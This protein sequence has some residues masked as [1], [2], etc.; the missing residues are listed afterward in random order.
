M[1]GSVSRVWRVAMTELSAAVRSRRA[2]VVTLLFL[3][4]AV[5]VMYGT[6]SAFAAME[7]EVLA[8]LGLPASDHPGSVTTALW[9]SKPFLRV[10][11]RMVGDSL[12]FADIRGR[13]PILLA[14]AMFIFQIVPLLTLMVSAPR[15][16][17]DL[18]SGAARYW[19]VRV[20]RTEWSLGKF[21][22]EAALLA[23]AMLGGA[24]AAWAVVV[25][26][27]PGLSGAG[28]LPGLVDWSARAWLYAFGWL[29]LFMGLSHIV[30]SGGKATALGILALLGAAAWSPMLGNFT[31]ALPWLE[32]LDGLVPQSA[33][34]CLWRR[35]VPA[36]AFGAVHLA[37]LAFL[38]LSLGAAV[39]RRRDV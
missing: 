13:H 25:W 7:R 17:D 37:A 32:H 31:D 5:I 14:Y 12:V 20:T 24:L 39:F 2:L 15:V 1:T 11:D 16:A 28:L 3:A 35:S 10:I 38:Y 9:K 4:V 22:G 33:Q 26:R 34:A 19:L 29:G 8:G 21:L 27:L 30:R 36:L 18:R 6:I 23:A